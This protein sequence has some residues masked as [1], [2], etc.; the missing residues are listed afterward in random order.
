MTVDPTTNHA[1]DRI[2]NV[3]HNE[4]HAERMKPNV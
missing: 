1:D 3:E 4:S 2:E